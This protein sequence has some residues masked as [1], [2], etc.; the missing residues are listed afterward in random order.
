MAVAGVAGRTGPQGDM[1]TAA[2]E[3]AATAVAGV[4]EAGG[5]EEEGAV[6]LE[7][8]GGLE[9]PVNP[10]VALEDRQPPQPDKPEDAHPVEEAQMLDELHQKT[11]HF[12]IAGGGL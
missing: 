12:S 4:E 7:L 9:G 3:V 5:V 11:G 2:A 6:A 8:E 1:V 10:I